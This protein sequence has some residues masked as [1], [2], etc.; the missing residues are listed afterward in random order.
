MQMSEELMTMA[1]KH[2]SNAKAGVLHIALQ[3]K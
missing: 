1:V 3:K 2:S